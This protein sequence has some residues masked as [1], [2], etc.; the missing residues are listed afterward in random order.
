MFKLRGLISTTIAA[1]L[2]ASAASAATYG[3]TE[4]WRDRV[5][6]TV[7]LRDVASDKNSAYDFGAL[8]ADDVASVHGR[9]QHAVDSFAFTATANMTIGF[10]TGGLDLHN[11]GTTSESGF[12]SENALVKVGS[13][14]LFTESVA[15][16]GVFDLLV[17]SATYSTD[18]AGGANL[19][20]ATAG[21]NYVLSI[22]G[23]GQDRRY[24]AHYDIRISA[25]P[26][27]ATAL[28]LMAGM[29]GL[30]SMRRRKKA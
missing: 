26:L 5:A 2:L 18:T 16:S 27:P 14:N 12:V 7:R 22:D 4:G 21:R 10:I 6:D 1:G 20:T 9:L 30:A 24:A 25:V 8:G 19:F 15:G 13:F 23:S 17:S 3:V 29:G 28:L 11:G